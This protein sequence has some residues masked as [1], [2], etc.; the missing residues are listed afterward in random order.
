VLP[1]QHPGLLATW[2]TA[3]KIRRGRGEVRMRLRQY[4]SRMG[5]KP[6]S[7]RRNPQATFQTISRHSA[8]MASPVA[9]ALQGL[10]HHHRGDHLGGHRRVA[11]ALPDDIGEQLR[12]VRL[13]AVVGEKGVQRPSGTRWRH[14][15]AASIWSSE[16]DVPG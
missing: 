13:V 8:L 5:W 14:Q 16:H 2:R 1:E 15:L 6:R 3:S 10:E 4:T 7:S 11:A 12:Q 9:Q